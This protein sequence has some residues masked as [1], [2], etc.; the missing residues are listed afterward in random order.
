VSLAWELIPYSFV[1]DW[2]VDVGSYLRNLET[3]LLYRK[4]VTSGYV[5]ELYAFEGSEV[6][7]NKANGYA[8]GSGKSNENWARFL[9]V[10]AKIRRV[11]FARTKLSSYPLPRLPTFKVALGSQRLFSAAALLRQLLQ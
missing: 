7:I 5:S 11:Q 4:F 6:G 8:I 3:A 2:F 9:N 1:V 10:K